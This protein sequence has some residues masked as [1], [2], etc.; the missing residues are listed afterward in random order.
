MFNSLEG[1][2]WSPLF[3]SPPLYHKGPTLEPHVNENLPKYAKTFKVSQ[4]IRGL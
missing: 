3:E 1:H 4:N 2:L